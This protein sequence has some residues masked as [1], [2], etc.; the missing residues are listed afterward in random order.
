MYDGLTRRG[1]VRSGRVQHAI[2]H[3]APQRRGRVHDGRAPRVGLGEHLGARQWELGQR[4][5]LRDDE[6][7]GGAT[8]ETRQGVEQAPERR[9][10]LYAPGG[11]VAASEEWADAAGVGWQA[12]PPAVC[13]RRGGNGA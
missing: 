13:G 8:R 6:R 3:R 4:D 5:R 11:A 12:G 9:S 2:R 1:E 10:A 7:R